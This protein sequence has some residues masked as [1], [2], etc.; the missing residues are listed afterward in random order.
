MVTKFTSATL[1]NLPARK[2]SHV[3]T[4]ANCKS[5]SRMTTSPL[6]L[7]KSILLWRSNRLCRSLYLRRIDS[8]R[9]QSLF[10]TRKSPTWSRWD[11]LSWLQSRNL[12]EFRLTSKSALLRCTFGTTK[13]RA[14]TTSLVSPSCSVESRAKVA[15][16]KRVRNT[17][18][19]RWLRRRRMTTGTV[20]FTR[21]R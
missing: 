14:R 9:S 8:P 20:C 15:R 5:A 4:A 7:Y 17:S 11:C 10:S 3:K 1:L 18:K 16:T 2:T 12:L 13:V 19:W 21:R 6:F